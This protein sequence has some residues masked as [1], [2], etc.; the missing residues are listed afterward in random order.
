[1]AKFPDSSKA[2]AATPVGGPI[3]TTKMGEGSTV[4]EQPPAQGTPLTPGPTLSG[5]Q[6]PTAPAPV[7]SDLPRD[8][9]VSPSPFRNMIP[10]IIGIGAFILLGVL[11]FMVVPRFFGGGGTTPSTLTYWGLWEPSSVMQTV[12][13]DYERET[14]IKV[15]Y[16]M[17]NIKGY[18]SR[19]QSAVAE[20]SGPDV[21]R[22]HNTWLPM[23][24]KVFTPAPADLG[25]S[26]SDYYPV[27]TKDLVVGNSIY[28]L[29][30]EI[31]GLALYYNKDILAEA[32][33]EPPTDWNALR[34]LAFDLT[35]RN[36]VT[37]VIERAGAAIGTANNIDHWSDIL[38]LL[39]LQNSGD[40]ATPSTQAVQDAL[41]F[42][43]IFATTD[44]SWDVSQPSQPMP[45][46]LAQ[47]P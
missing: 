24:R 27:V 13:A 26:L 25:I 18:R 8:G 30:L 31:D 11:A 37:G 4:F 5:S 39:I 46:P 43:T 10:L 38:G 33:A 28:A 36:E 17:Q 7:I 32:G 42:Y 16:S 15:N 44:K 41:T 23:M 40:P 34:K 47:L 20:G 9:R 14:G 12:L 21:V 2:Y 1:M 19:L 35:Q 6:T 29:P 3:D 22:I 45:L